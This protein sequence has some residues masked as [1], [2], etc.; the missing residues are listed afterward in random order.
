MADEKKK[1][2]AHSG[3]GN[4]NVWIWVIVILVFLIFATF[5]LSKPFFSPDFL[6]LEYF[7]NQIFPFFN[8]GRGGYSWIGP[9]L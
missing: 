9:G 7:F 2:S 3:G 6:N 4:E 8:V 5:G 1:P